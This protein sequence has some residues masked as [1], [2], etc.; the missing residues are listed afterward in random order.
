MCVCLNLG[1]RFSIVLFIGHFPTANPTLK[2]LCENRRF[3]VFSGSCASRPH[4][5]RPLVGL[6]CARRGLGRPASVLVAHDGAAALAVVADLAGEG[7]RGSVRERVSG[8]HGVLGRARVATRVHC[9]G[10]EVSAR[11]C[12]CVCVRVC[13]RARERICVCV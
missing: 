9:D 6:T 5:T 8:A 12:A 3:H 4:Q 7:Q 1:F 10:E 2:I 11:V 13:V